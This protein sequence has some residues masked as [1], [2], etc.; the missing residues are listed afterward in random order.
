MPFQLYTSVG[1]F[2]WCYALAYIGGQLGKRWDS[3]PRLRALMH[4]FDLIVVVMVLAAIGRFVWHKLR[5]R[6]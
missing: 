4:R 5:R 2:V 6:V 1:S 3:D